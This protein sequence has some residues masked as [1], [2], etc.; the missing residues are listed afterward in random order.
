MASMRGASVVLM[1]KYCRELQTMKPYSDGMD[2]QIIW[3]RCSGCNRTKSIKTMEYQQMVAASKAPRVVAD[4]ECV[5]YDPS[6]KFMVGQVLYHPLWDDSGE[7]I[8]KLKTKEGKTTIVVA[9]TRLGERRLI[10]AT[11][12]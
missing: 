5:K 4:G 9:F 12:G 8:R 10:E 3:L 1:C 7:V 6:Q 11:Q 2:G